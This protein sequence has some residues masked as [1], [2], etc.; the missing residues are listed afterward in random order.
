[1]RNLLWT[2]FG[3]AV[4]IFGIYFLVARHQQSPQMADTLNGKV[5]TIDNKE[6]IDKKD[7]VAT[8]PVVPPNKPSTTFMKGYWDGYN[9]TWLAPIRW[10]FVDDY[11]QGWSLGS[12]D[13]K[14]GIK[15]YNPEV[16]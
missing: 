10:T 3:L 1:M 16:R 9:G 4:L 7:Q 6:E 2:M 15:R 14:N 11:R 8:P 13:R 12:H 5:Q